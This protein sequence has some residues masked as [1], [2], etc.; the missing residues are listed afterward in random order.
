MDPI[1]SISTIENALRQGIQRGDIDIEV[2]REETILNA[3]FCKDGMAD[4]SL[5][6]KSLNNNDSAISSFQ[7]NEKV[8]KYFQSLTSLL[9]QQEMSGGNLCFA[10]QN[11]DLRD[12]YK[13]V[14]SL[15]DVM[16]YTY[17]CICYQ[18]LIN[19]SKAIKV[20]FPSDSS[21]FWKLVK[22]GGKLKVLHQK[23]EPFY[24][25]NNA[26]LSVKDGASIDFFKFEGDRI[27]F[28][29][30]DYF[31][32]ITPEMMDFRVGDSYPLKEW[33]NLVLN[34]KWDKKIENEFLRIIS[35][36]QQT[37]RWC[38]GYQKWMN[39]K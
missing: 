26:E 6:V 16:H 25:L 29:D 2:F 32:G 7:L 28:N 12:D 21:V 39:N 34:K 27:F 20:D 3:V 15:M 9:Y 36:A 35:I 10:T 13:V 17:A 23:K 33:Q 30:V 37:I 8:V 14:F 22:L 31:R 18:S 5:F 1:L 19:R 24:K 11:S 38:E 4:E